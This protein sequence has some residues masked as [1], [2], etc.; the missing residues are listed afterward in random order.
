MKRVVLTDRALSAIFAAL[1]A[2]LAGPE[3]EG[4]CADT[5]HADFERAQAR[6]AS[7]RRRRARRATRRATKTGS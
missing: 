7:E 6:V 3:G 1:A 4:D 5:P 2:Q